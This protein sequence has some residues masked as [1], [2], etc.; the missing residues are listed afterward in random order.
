MIPR[1]LFPALSLLFAAFAVVT[2]PYAHTPESS[3]CRWGGCRFT[4]I[5]DQVHKSGISDAGMKALLAEDPANPDQWC[6]YGEFLRTKKDLPGAKNAYDRA[7]T[8]GNG[9]VSVRMRAVN[10]YFANGYPEDAM[11]QVPTILSTTA[12]FDEPLFSYV[13]RS[14]TP[15]E[16]T[17]G[18]ILPVKPRPARAWLNWL[19]EQEQAEQQIVATWSWMQQH[20]LLDASS[21]SRTV[22]ALW[23]QKEY[24]TARRLWSDWSKENPRGHAQLLTNANFQKAPE[25]VPFDWNLAPSDS[26]RYQTNN[27]LD[28]QFLGKENID[29]QGVRQSVLLTPGRYRFSA[30]VASDD[31]TT[32][33]G[34]FFVITDPDNTAR[35][36]VQSPPLRGAI[37]RSPVTIDF[38]AGPST[39]VVVIRLA[40][41]PSLKFDS[42][43]AG[44]LHIYSTSLVPLP[45]REK[46]L[47][48]FR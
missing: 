19:L 34:P 16:E 43:I 37:A 3:L 2:E 13:F 40:R 21:A 7:V 47:S 30:D 45:A 28:I 32:D 22:N 36:D 4:Q 1:L 17:L 5:F 12:E 38:T 41:K 25:P 33:Q 27:G 46:L 39:R 15:I 31:L 29:Y 48:S 14:V 44:R 10:F 6:A 26:V 24:S 9:L 20:K 11:R 8:L 23:Q 18:T 42:K 35:L